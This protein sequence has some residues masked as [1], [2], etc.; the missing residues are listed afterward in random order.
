[1][2]KMTE[3][4][5]DTKL[6]ELLKPNDARFDWVQDRLWSVLRSSEA[7]SLSA[8]AMKLMGLLEDENAQMEDLERVIE[9]DPGLA[10]RCI[11]VASSVM[12]G[13]RSISSIQQALM[14]IGFAEIRR[15]AC[16]IGVVDSFS[17]LNIKVDW[18]KF[19]L[20]SVLVGRLTQAIAGH[21]RE[22][23]G[24]EYLAGLLHDMG[25]LIVEH[26]FPKEFE[27]ILLK[28]L[29]R[30]CGHA[31]VE[32]HLLGIDHA[33][34]GAAMCFVMKVAPS[35]QDAVGHHHN[36][37]GPLSRVRQLPDK[38]FLAACVSLADSLAN[39]IGAGL[40]GAKPVI[41]WEKL[42]AWKYLAAEFN[43]PAPLDLDLEEEA[44]RAK[45]DLGSLELVP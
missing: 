41:D 21:F 6:R 20:H 33:R 28:S 9:V 2:I 12:Y 31:V 24:A 34:I 40:A 38:G 4:G 45:A 8:S 15:M 17:R 5:T 27:T 42:D 29:E 14:T 23:T 25:K 10:S 1:M 11:R 22:V 7:P 36:V 26:N 39:S 19:W 32:R 37:F 43:S 35:V 3:A 16:A 44:E 30:G 13:A 18:E